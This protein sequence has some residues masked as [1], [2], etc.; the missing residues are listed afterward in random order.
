MIILDTNFLIY[1]IK[2]KLAHQLE[3]HKQEFAVPEQVVYEIEMLSRDAEKIKDREYAKLA[4]VLLERWKPQVLNESGNADEAILSLAVKNKAK[5]ATMDK[6]LSKKL[7]KAGVRI[8][9][10][11]QK[12][13]ISS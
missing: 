12:K 8:M 2:Y 9:Q 11:R 10:I 7:E 6:I 3:E 4:L 1:M 5:V 13:K